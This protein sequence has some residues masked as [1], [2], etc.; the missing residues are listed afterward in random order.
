MKP[1]L[2][3]LPI[4]IVT[5]FFLIRADL[6]KDSRQIYIFKPISTT[7]LIL[8]A[9]LSYGEITTNATYTLGILIGLTLSFGGD[10]ALMFQSNRKAFTL[11]L[12]LFLTAHLAYAVTFTRLA[13][14]SHWQI[15]LL[16]LALSASFYRLLYT[17]L[18]SMKIPV[19]GYICIISMMVNQ[20]LATFSS[21]IFSTS[22]AWLISTGALLFYISDMFLALNRYWKP[23]KYQR[24]SLA[25][26]YGGQFLI[27]LTA[28]HFI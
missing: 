19:L 25:F 16:L 6:R 1:A 4:L 8:T 9:L 20:A 13:N 22:Q 7:L 10:I 23:F 26:Y 27:A 28:S 18:G 17:G 5:V 11:G 24:I 2:F 15:T 3:P 14:T 12:V 21:N